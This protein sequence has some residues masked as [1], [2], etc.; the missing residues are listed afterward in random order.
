MIY[1]SEVV[2]P[3]TG[4]MDCGGVGFGGKMVGSSE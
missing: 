1:C 4:N 2:G 3:D